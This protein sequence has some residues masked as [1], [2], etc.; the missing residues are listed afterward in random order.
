MGL[1]QLIN[2]LVAVTLVEMM[3]ATGLSV[4]TGEVFHVVRDRNLNMR[5]GLANYVAV[6]PAA[7][8]LL[9]SVEP[10]PPVA[11]GV[12]ILAVCPG[13]S[14]A[15]PMTAFAR[16]ATA[17]AV[18]LMIILA[19]SSIVVS[20][21]LLFCLLPVTTGEAN[22]QLDPLSLLGTIT[23]TQLLP[24]CCGLAIS[25][26]RPDWAK[27][28]LASATSTGKVLNAA[29]LTAILVSQ[30]SRLV[31]IRPDAILCMLLLL[32]ISL[33]AGWSAGGRRGQDRRA[34]AV[35]TVI[36]NVG[37]GLVIASST[38]AGTPVVA[39]V[40]IY[41]I[42]QLAISLLVALRWRRSKLPIAA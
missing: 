8:A 28:W 39:T 14:Y 24:L 5:A 41:G 13:A 20:P 26:W 36:R 7:V 3:L 6:P 1:D 9:L 29:S 19:A 10:D 2:V 23:L 38:Y 21:F 17:T 18:G 40:L 34:V 33:G 27:M 30:F 12:L 31:Q 32:G 15:P 16:G 11:A 4:R 37:L 42:M 35:T 25:H 22:L